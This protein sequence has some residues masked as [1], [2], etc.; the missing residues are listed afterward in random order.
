MKDG[1][2]IMKASYSLLMT[3]SSQDCFEKNVV[4]Q[5]SID[6]QSIMLVG[7]LNQAILGYFSLYYS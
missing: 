6:A 1:Q 4:D 3:N 2:K 5:P 7:W